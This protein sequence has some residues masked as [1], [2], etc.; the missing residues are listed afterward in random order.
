MMNP[1]MD[2]YAKTYNHRKIIQKTHKNNNLLKTER[3]LKPKY[4]QVG[5]GFHI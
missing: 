1:D 2:G 4:K 5:S 3:I